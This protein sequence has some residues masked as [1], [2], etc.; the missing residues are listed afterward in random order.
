MRRHLSTG[1]E[2]LGALAIVAGAAIVFG[3]G[4]AL[5]AAG[6]LAIAFGLALDEPARRLRR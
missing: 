2:V 4:W 1:L 3:L 6:A 5:L